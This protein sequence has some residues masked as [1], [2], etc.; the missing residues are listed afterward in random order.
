MPCTWLHH[1]ICAYAAVIR[2]LYTQPVKFYQISVIS[3][4]FF[5]AMI[6]RDVFQRDY[7]ITPV[8]ESD[9]TLELIF[10]LFWSSRFQYV[11]HKIDFDSVSVRGSQD[12]LWFCFRMWLTRVT[13]ILFSVCGSQDWLWFC[14]Q[15]VAHKIDF[16]VDTCSFSLVNYSK[17][18]V[19]LSVGSMMASLENRPDT[20]SFK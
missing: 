8:S 7:F 16:A 13:L 19:K 10:T 6:S 20:D 15:Y 2:V 3:N 4:D 1:A 5:I 12:W 9:L 18:V 11:A 17:E 14:F